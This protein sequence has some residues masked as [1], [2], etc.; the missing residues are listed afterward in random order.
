M[1]L[2]KQTQT[3]EVTTDRICNMFVMLYSNT[4]ESYLNKHVLRDYYVPGTV[5]STL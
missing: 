5:L 3:R 4:F 1:Q 2:E